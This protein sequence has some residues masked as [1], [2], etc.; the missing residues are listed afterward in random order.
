[1]GYGLCSYHSI[2]CA[3]EVYSIWVR[4][5]R[6]SAHCSEQPLYKISQN[7][8]IHLAEDLFVFDQKSR[9]IC[10]SAL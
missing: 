3:A 2:D 5:R 7:G 10:Y 8:M 6:I 1:M 4:P 9:L